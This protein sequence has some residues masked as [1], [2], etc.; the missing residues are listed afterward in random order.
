M[1]SIYVL[2]AITELPYGPAQGLPWMAIAFR[3]EED[4]PRRQRGLMPFFNTCRMTVMLPCPC[5]DYATFGK[6]MHHGICDSEGH[7]GTA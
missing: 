3:W 4:L 1:T 2:M 6:N 5:P 7:Y